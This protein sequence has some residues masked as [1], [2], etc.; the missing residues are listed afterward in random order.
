MTAPIAI[1]FAPTD[2]DG[3]A[4]LPGRVA[5]LIDPE[6]RKAAKAGPVKALD[7]ASGGA[8]ARAMASK[9]WDKL[10][11]GDA[12]SLAWPAG[13]AAESLSLIKL[14]E[15]AAQSV[16]RKAGAGLAK[17]IPED[18]LTLLVGA[19]PG[20][21]EIAFG[22]AL[23][24]YDFRSHKTGEAPKVGA[25]T[26]QSDK[27]E[28][29]AAAA[30]DHA[31][32]A[33]GVFFTRDL[34]NEPANVLTTDDFAARLAAMQELGLDI[35]IL[36]EADLEKL[37]MRAL[38]GVGQ[39]SESPSKV[40][41][42]QWNGGKKGRAP[43]ALV[44]KG[45]V[46]DTGG[47]SI[48]PAAGMEEMTMDMGGAAVV[49]GVMR[50]LALRKA[51]ANVV[52]LVG[53]VENMPDGRAQRP[54]DIVRS[55]KGD[56]IEIINTDAE[57]RLVLA[58]VLWYAQ[59]RFQPAAMIDLATLTGAIII[60]L[61]H[62]NAGVFSNDDALAGAITAAAE[63]EGEGAWR[64]PMGPT[65]D[66]QLK[67]RLADMK[68]TGTRAG[69]SI[70]AAQFLQRF[71][72]AETPWAHIDI[73][74]VAMPPGETTLAPKGATGWGVMTLNRLI[75]DQAEGGKGW[76]LAV[77]GASGD[78]KAQKDGKGRGKKGKN[79]KPKADRD[80]GDAVKGFPT[81]LHDSGDGGTAP[82]G[83]KL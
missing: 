24:A 10:A 48:K 39:G 41:V 55:M 25:V 49:A 65:Y 76:A 75:A 12:L 35:E 32:L 30:A 66:E 29:L 83:H 68:N 38:L 81:D 9:A 63:A 11:E 44:G 71:V 40:V 52:G 67:S 26:I 70:T 6:D 15:A 16:L 51:K 31:A 18:G 57:G 59:D 82:H 23:R 4:H 73:A 37:G 69:G 60:A 2:L 14:T 62:D 28:K 79:A 1:R 19:H 13:M 33:E 27:P 42:M 36:D 50:T 58:D 3:L 72:K 5:M 47:I 46:F 20:S 7:K 22:L 45:V 74:G 17:T 53:L 77:R 78:G 54:G 34:V 64:L 8:V 61:G 43:L 56:T 80:T 21:A